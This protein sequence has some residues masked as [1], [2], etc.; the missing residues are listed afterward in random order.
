MSPQ[1]SPQ[2]FRTDPLFHFDTLYSTSQNYYRLPQ[3]KLMWKLITCPFVAYGTFPCCIMIQRLSNLWC[4]EITIE[5]SFSYIKNLVLWKLLLVSICILE[6]VSF[7]QLRS[8][9]LSLFSSLYINGNILWPIDYWLITHY[10][11]LSM[12]DEQSIH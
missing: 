5:C 9:A 1:C 8:Q 11:L 6:W 4:C 7:A 2:H 12:T 3:G 10:C